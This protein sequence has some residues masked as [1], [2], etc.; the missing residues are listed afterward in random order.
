MTT[1]ESSFQ[2]GE[3]FVAARLFI[4]I[5]ADRDT[6][7]DISLTVPESG[8]TAGQYSDVASCRCAV[9]GRGFQNVE[10]DRHRSSGR[11]RTADTSLI[12]VPDVSTR[13][14]R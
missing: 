3:D 8:S 12:G 11:C 6:L 2:S 7:D 9:C 4:D 13:A 5:P 14:S 10:F 1:G